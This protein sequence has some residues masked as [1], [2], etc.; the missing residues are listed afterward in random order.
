MICSIAMAWVY[1]PS[2]GHGTCNQCNPIPPI[3]ANTPN[4]SVGSIHPPK[5]DTKEQCH[6][7]AASI[8]FRGFEVL[9]QTWV[10]IRYRSR[11]SAFSLPGTHQTIS[12]PAWYFCKRYFQERKGVK[13]YFMIIQ[14]FHT[15]PFSNTNDLK[16]L[17][18]PVK[19]H[20]LLRVVS[21]QRLPPEGFRFNWE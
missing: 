17:H 6:S 21:L 11:L 4:P 8:P 14:V 1:I 2:F 3:Y 18:P 15:H 10:W 7:L 19:P 13:W 20:V 16:L 12:K 5:V 9:A